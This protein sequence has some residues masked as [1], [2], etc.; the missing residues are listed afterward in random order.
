[1]S[2]GQYQNNP[3]QDSSLAEQGYQ[4]HEL[5]NYPEQQQV[6][7]ILSQQDFLSRI[8][9]LR[10]EI[11]TL[12]NNVQSIASLHQ[13][14]LAEGDGGVASQQLERLVADTQTLNIGIRDQLKFLANDAVK[15][16]V[17]SSTRTMKQRQVDAIK[18]EFERELTRYREEE[19]LYSQRYRDQIARQYRIVNPEASEDEVRK[20]ADTDWGNEGVFQ[21]ALRSNRAGQASSVL[22][23][24][25]ARHNELQRIERT[26]I[27]LAN[28]F[29]DLAILVEQQDHAVNEAVNNAE[30]TTKYIDEGNTHVK[31]GIVHARNRRKLKWWCLFVVIIIIAIALGVGLGV[32]ANAGLLGN[33][34]NSNNNNS[35]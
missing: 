7:D 20:A 26:L 11:G 22:G 6:S 24:V 19:S 30:N 9:F 34:N 12:T 25:R 33:H 8:Q 4:E 35:G 5:Q 31:K 32:A 17:D 23:A 2:Y 15:S 13:R 10:N 14:A 16:P 18:S 29:Q 21:T 27:E 3:Y 1:M 28:M